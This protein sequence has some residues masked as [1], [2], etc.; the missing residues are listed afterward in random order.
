VATHPLYLAA[1]ALSLVGWALFEL[2]HRRRR[3]DAQNPSQRAARLAHANAKKRLRA[4]ENAL[5][6]G[7][8]KDFYGQL[9]RTLTSYLEERANLPATGMTHGEL[10]QAARAAGYPA[11]LVDRWVVEMENCDFARFAPSGSAADR[12]KEA[13]ERVGQL[14]DAL[15]RITPERRP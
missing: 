1:L 10:R 6:D 13:A 15:D 7:L 4:A 12:M 9:A 3:L 8:V 11:D 2:A 5:R 14:I